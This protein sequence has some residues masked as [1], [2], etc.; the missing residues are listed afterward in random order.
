MA[1]NKD[2]EIILKEIFLTLDVEY[3]STPPQSSVRHSINTLRKAPKG[4]HRDNHK[5][6]KKRLE[7]EV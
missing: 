3:T 7:L 6:N 4:D 1:T 5:I 2:I